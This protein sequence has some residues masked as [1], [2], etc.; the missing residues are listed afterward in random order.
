MDLFHF[1]KKLVWLPLAAVIFLNGCFGTDGSGSIH[2]G[3]GFASDTTAILLYKLWEQP[4]RGPLDIFNYARNYYGWEIKLVDVRFNKVYWSAR[5]EHDMRN[6]QILTGRQWNDSTML[7]ELTGE[8]Y[9][10]WTV[11]NKKPQKANFKWNC[12]M[13]NYKSDKLERL[14]LYQGRPSHPRPWKNNSLL[15]PGA[16]VVVDTKT[17]TV[18][19]WAPPDEDAWVANCDDFW[20]GKSGGVCLVNNNP[21]GFTLLSEKGDTLGSFTYAHECLTYLPYYGKKCN[22]SSHFSYN[23]IEASLGGCSVSVCETCPAKS[24]ICK[25]SYA[26]IRYDDKWNVDKEPS[27]WLLYEDAGN[28]FVDSLQNITRY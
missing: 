8:G 19:D 16:K 12:E 11:G 13:E 14:L 7:I 2:V 5:V 23:F 10:L 6:T 28:G 25:T 22:I 18:N 27:F 21:Y 24:I 26:Y 15:F 17:M 9:W 3:D 20:H 4:D 1:L